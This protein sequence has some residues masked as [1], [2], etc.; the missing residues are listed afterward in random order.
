MPRLGSARDQQ[1]AVM[2]LNRMGDRDRQPSR[3]SAPGTFRLPND[4]S[5]DTSDGPAGPGDDIGASGRNRSSRKERPRRNSGQGSSYGQGNAS[6][7]DSDSD[8]ERQKPEGGTAAQ[9]QELAVYY[10]SQAP[11][12]RKELTDRLVEKEYG[13]EEITQALDRLT[14]LG[15]VDDALFAEQ[16][17]RA[18]AARGQSAMKIGQALREAGVDRETST[19][20]LSAGIDPDSELATARAL[21]DRKIGATR[22]LPTQKRT[23]RLVGMLARRGYGPIAYDVVREA[24]ASESEPT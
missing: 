9:A 14:E 13:N 22:G 3:S 17:V 11:R 18:R 16:I 12:S 1:G 5:G 24:L 19:E 4:A 20:A 8:S 23:A 21:V 6:R 10:L 15:Y 2:A 7:R